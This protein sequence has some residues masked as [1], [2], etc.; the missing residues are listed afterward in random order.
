MQFNINATSTDGRSKQ[1]VVNASCI[2]N[3]EK[4]AKNLNKYFNLGGFKVESFNV[5]PCEIVHFTP[6][7]AQKCT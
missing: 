7:N 6:K 4:I 5:T 1:L 2:L 3:A